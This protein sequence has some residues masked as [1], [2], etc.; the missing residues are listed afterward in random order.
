[1]VW[2]ITDVSLCRE[3][4]AAGR[5]GFEG[6]EAS[7]VEMQGLRCQAGPESIDQEHRVAWTE[8]KASL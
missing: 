4:A 5:T 6:L 2:T 7:L 8:T 1:M 3:A